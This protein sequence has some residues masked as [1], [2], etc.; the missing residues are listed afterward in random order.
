MPKT[1]GAPLNGA[2]QNAPPAE[3]H[4]NKLMPTPYDL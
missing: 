1:A 4:G 2:T 3:A